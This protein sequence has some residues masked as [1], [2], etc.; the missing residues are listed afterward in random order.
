MSEWDLI[1]QRPCPMFI[2]CK[3]V[4]GIEPKVFSTHLHLSNFSP[5]CKGVNNVF[6]FFREILTH[7]RKNA[8]DQIQ[9][10]QTFFFVRFRDLVTNLLN[11]IV[12][13]LQCFLQWFCWHSLLLLML[14]LGPACLSDCFVFFLQERLTWV[15]S[16]QRSRKS[17]QMRR[18]TV[19]PFTTFP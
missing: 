15:F 9:T 16:R 19:Q 4:S 12:I 7:V 8:Q 5:K 6:D 14:S 13:F 11:V 3:I 10:Y 2:W 17:C 18:V 1:S